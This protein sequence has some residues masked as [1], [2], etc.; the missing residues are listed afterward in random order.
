MKKWTYLVSG[1][2][3]GAI[4]AT[5]GNAFADQISMIGK[6]VTGEYTVIVDGKALQDK[7]AVID[8]R[9]NVPVR[10]ITQALGAD[11]KVE[12]KKIIVTTEQDR[13]SSTDNSSTSKPTSDNKY[14]GDS[15]E[16]LEALKD[17]I[18]NRRLKPLVKERQELL[19]EIEALKKV[20]DSVPVLADKEKRVQEYDDM[21]SKESEELRLVNEALAALE[22]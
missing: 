1:I 2:V 15:K 17:S 6:K 10:G 14:T 13:P 20:G 22:K 4:L 7:G 5:A 11:F 18:E 19:T 9:T 3:V 12:G 21:I 16:S 8:G